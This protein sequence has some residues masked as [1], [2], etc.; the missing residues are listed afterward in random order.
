MLIKTKRATA[1]GGTKKYKV[2][3]WYSDYEALRNDQQ[4]QI[5]D[6]SARNRYIR[7]SPTYCQCAYWYY[8]IFAAVLHKIKYFQTLF[9]FNDHIYDILHNTP[10]YKNII[11]CKHANVQHLLNNN[12]S[13]VASIG[14]AHC[15]YSSY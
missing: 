9:L 1:R 13:C 3:E 12:S 10:Y 4:C 5:P 14:I 2:G 8:C 7:L 15:K 11:W 6:T